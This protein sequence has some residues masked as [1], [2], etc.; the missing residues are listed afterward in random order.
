M[1]RAGL[2]REMYSPGG[3]GSVIVLEA[4]SAED[5]TSALAALPLVANKIIEFEV[6]ELRPFAAF[7]MLFSEAEQQ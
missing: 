4:D 3:P 5:A 2:V 6:I 7:E 1:Y